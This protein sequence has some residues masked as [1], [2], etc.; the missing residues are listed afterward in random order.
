MD[1]TALLKGEIELTISIAAGFMLGTLILRTGL[2]DKLMKHLM[3]Y[4]KKAGIGSVLGMALTVSLGSAKA[5]AALIAAAYDDGRISERTAKWGTLMLSFPAY[6]H[7]W[8]STMVMAASMAGISGAIFAAVI[9]LRTALRFV[10]LI[11][12]YRRGEHNDL[13]EESERSE[14]SAR[15][16][17]VAS[18]ILK[19]LP[20]AWFFYAVA[21]ALVP[22]AEDAM[23]DWLLGGKFLPLAGLAV[24]AASIAHVS[25]ALALA[26]GSLAAGDL[27]VSQ[28][29]FALLLGNSFGIVS[30]MVRANAGYYFGLFPGRLAKSM[31]IWN[32][33]TTAP[34]SILTILLAAIPLFF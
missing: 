23:K 8:P 21:F 32:L 19:S 9:L 18:K 7:R 12:I 16:V 26:G 13:T 14:T 28:A 1:W 34:L 11:F 31:L 29:V 3:P 15:G 24:A 33:G 25:A 4:L 22:W 10:L 20:L 30:R 2:A 27:N 6:L 5:G 17:K